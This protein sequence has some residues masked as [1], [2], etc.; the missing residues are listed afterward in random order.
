M[1]TSGVP[2]CGAMGLAASWERWEYWDVGS[3]S[4][5]AQW[6]KDPALS[7]TRLGSDPWPKN[8][9]CCKGAK[10][11]KEGKKK[12]SVLLTIHNS[13]DMKTT[14]MSIDR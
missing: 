9:I 11:K 6:V 10:N 1:C 14:L 8:S 3:I 7:R 2:C 4:G 12:K 5:P 13:Q